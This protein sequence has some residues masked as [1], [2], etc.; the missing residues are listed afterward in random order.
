MRCA[1]IDQFS[2]AQVTVSR[3]SLTVQLKDIR[4]QRVQDTGNRDNPGPPCGPY[5]FPRQ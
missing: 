4:G 5:V 2:Y 3:R 1:A